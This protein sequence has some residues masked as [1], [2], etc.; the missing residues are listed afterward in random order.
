MTNYEQIGIQTALVSAVIA[1]ASVIVYLYKNKLD[2]DK[3]MIKTILSYEKE[4]REAEKENSKT[5]SY[6]AEKFHQFTDNL[7]SIIKKN[8]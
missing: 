5:A 7:K 3:E 1:L 2:Q 8:D 4:L 6:F